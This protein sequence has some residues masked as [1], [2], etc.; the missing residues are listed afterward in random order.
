MKNAIHFKIALK[1]LIISFFI[2]YFPTN[3]LAQYT[4][5]GN[6]SKDD[7]NCY[8]LTPD[9]GTQHGSVWN[10]NKISLNTSFDYN[11]TVFLGYNDPGADGIA[12]VLQP[13]STSV[14]STGGGLGYQGITPAIGVTID[15]Y[16]NTDV[17]DPVYDHIAIQKN[18]DLD[19]NTAN[20]IAG[21]VQALLNS[22]NIED[23]AFHTFRVVWDAV[24]KKFDSYLD[25]D[26][27]V[28]VNIDL[29]NSVFGGD[30]MVYW[31]FTGS[32]GG[33]Q[34][35]QRFCTKNIAS[36]AVLDP[37]TYCD[38]AT[39]AFSDSS[40]SSSGILSWAWDFGDGATSTEQNPTHHYAQ[41]GS[42]NTTLYVIGNDGCNSDT[43]TIPIDVYPNPIANFSSLDGCLGYTTS[44]SDQSTIS[45]GSITNWDWDFGVTPTQ[46]SSNQNPTYTYTNSGAY[47]TSLITT[48]NKGCKDTVVKTV[49]VNPFPVAD[50]TVSNTTGCSPFCVDFINNSTISVGNIAQWT[51]NLG[52][53]ASSTEETPNNCYNNTTTA[54]NSYPVELI[55]KSDKG[56]SDTLLKPNFITV[57]PQ[58]KAQFTANPLVVDLNNTEITFT[59][60]SINATSYSWDFDDGSATS[61]SVNATHAFPS[62]GS[63]E[64]LVILTAK[65]SIGC[66][67]TASVKITVTAPDPIYEVP[68]VFSPN[69]D[70]KNDTFQL[71]N[72]ENIAETSIT[73]FNRWGNIVFE[74]MS[75]NFIWDGK[76]T[77]TKDKCSAGVYFYKLKIIGLNGK[78][79]NEQGY[80]HL[81]R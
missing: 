43:L 60:S 78:E 22:P 57:Y 76:T 74:N 33:A 50:F 27:R 30:P 47:S 8:T 77:I 11:F 63:G 66:M 51:W 58:P 64:Y 41:T 61:N 31:G 10:V 4:V 2:F 38:S 26:L 1:F 49:N 36:Y 24:N 34:N 72:P 75:F 69:D 7:C 9:A 56:C 44:F 19:H 12:F 40:L 13:I 79:M 81:I 80:V 70:G 17:G 48:S 5:N 35:L 23:G 54:A 55:V 52:N 32:T 65:N 68:N 62:T 29:V 15:T 16:Q 3:I 6:S 20:N 28:T 67:D 25:G 46:N 71:I 73:I 45:S 53:G 18:G 14:G 37:Q 21:P 39:V 59:N 42:Y